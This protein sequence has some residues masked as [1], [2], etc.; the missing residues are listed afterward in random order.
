MA[1][2][3][4]TDD[5]VDFQLVKNGIIG[6]ARVAAKVIV[7]DM[8]YQAAKMMDQQINIKHTNLYAYFKDKVNGVD[9]PNGYRYF[10]VML[11]NGQ[12]EVIG[13]PWVNE[14]TYKV[15]AGRTRSYVITN[16][17]QLMEGPL[18][19]ALRDLG[20]TYTYNDVTR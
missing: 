14:S 7:G 3:P 17:E 20:A 10:A 6:D 19:K 1:I 2:S 11:A 16:F 15:V 13:Y 4:V 12:M 9:D 8:T 5:I 18:H